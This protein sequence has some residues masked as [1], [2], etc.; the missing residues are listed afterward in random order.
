MYVFQKDSTHSIISIFID[1]I[2]IACKNQANIDDLAAQ[3]CKHFELHDIVP[4][5]WLLGI[6]INQDIAKGT[7]SLC[8]SL[9]VNDVLKRFGMENCGTRKTP[10]D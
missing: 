9:Y 8:Q 6:A 4:T 10:M 2:I 5:S 7:I 1:D 3:L